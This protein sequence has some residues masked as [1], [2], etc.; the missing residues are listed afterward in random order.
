MKL[1]MRRG[2]AT[3]IWVSVMLAAVAV[4][5]VAFSVVVLDREPRR[6]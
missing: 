3:V 4:A 1:T 6:Q 5:G 2:D